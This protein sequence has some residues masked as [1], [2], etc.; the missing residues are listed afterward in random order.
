MVDLS[1]LYDRPG[2]EYG[3]AVQPDCFADLNLD[4]IVDAVTAGRE[5]YDLK[6]FFY[7][8]TRDERTIR[9]RQDV[10][11][12]LE[13]PAVLDRI[14]RFAMSMRSVRAYLKSAGTTDI[15]NK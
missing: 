13:R 1:I 12:D 11:R 7:Q 14:N 4:Q 8:N 6:A 15:C 10:M 5:Q 3:E 9:Y 2:T